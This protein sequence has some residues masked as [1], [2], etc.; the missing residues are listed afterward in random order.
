MIEKGISVVICCYNSAWVIKDCLDCLIQQKKSPSLKWEIVL[1]DNACTDDTSGIAESALK[2]RNVDYHIVKEPVPGLVHARKAGI[3]IA[4]YS[5]ILFCDDDNLLCDN[6][7]DGMYR[8]M[9][10]DSSI[11]A[12]GGMGIPVLQAAPHP[13]VMRYIT[14]YAVGSQKANLSLG[15]L[16]GAGIC[17]RKE[18]YVQLEEKNI[19]F[20]LTGRAGTNLLAGDDTE[21]VKWVLLLGYRITCSDDLTFKHRLPKTRLTQEHLKKMF[22]GFGMSTPVLMVYNLMCNHKP[23][24]SLYKFFVLSCL[25]FI[26]NFLL[27][28]VQD[29]RIIPTLY[30]LYIIRGFFYWNLRHI[31]RQIKYY[32]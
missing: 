32:V 27:S 21:L 5:Y 30:N 24:V 10:G 20:I 9:E 23:Y 6:Y 22:Q 8:I 3:R 2:E 17:I 25:R 29:Y 11:G 28:F 15:M 13:Y 16:Y 19:E 12:C 26:Y 7:L 31:Y 4:R 14:C 18:I 1:V